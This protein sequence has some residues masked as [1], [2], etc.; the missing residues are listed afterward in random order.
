MIQ[1]IGNTACTQTLIYF[2]FVLF[3]IIA[4]FAFNHARSTDFE[5]K[6]ESL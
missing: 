4:V 6:I 1:L 3:D 5:Q 2:I